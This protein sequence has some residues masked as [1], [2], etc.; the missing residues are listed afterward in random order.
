MSDE[1]WKQK[2]KVKTQQDFLNVYFQEKRPQFRLTG[3]HKN[4][5]ICM[6]EKYREPWL[7]DRGWGGVFCSDSWS[8]HHNGSHVEYRYG[9]LRFCMIIR[10]S[11][12][13]TFG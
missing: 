7:S 9:T 4:S 3:R 5:K 10:N 6:K 12:K 11:E 13:L 1:H 8:Y 2:K